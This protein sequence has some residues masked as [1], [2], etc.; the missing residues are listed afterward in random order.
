MQRIDA[1]H[2]GFGSKSAFGILFYL[3]NHGDMHQDKLIHIWYG[4]KKLTKRDPK[5]P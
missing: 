2:I 1:L 5:T 4:I 3:D